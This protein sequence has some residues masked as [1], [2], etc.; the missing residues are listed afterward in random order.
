[1]H[2]R[3]RRVGEWFLGVGTGND[4]DAGAATVAALAAV[5]AAADPYY[6]GGERGGGN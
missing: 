2:Q 5:A 1:M 3:L 4:A 6:K